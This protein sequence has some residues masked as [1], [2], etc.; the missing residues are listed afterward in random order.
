MHYRASKPRSPVPRLARR[1][2]WQTLARARAP[3]RVP[4]LA[5]PR[6]SQVIFEIVQPL[7]NYPAPRAP[8]RSVR[9]RAPR[10][11]DHARAFER[12]L[13]RRRLPSLPLRSRDPPRVQGVSN[14]LQRRRADALRLADDRR[15]LGREGVGPCFLRGQH[16]RARSLRLGLPSRTPRALAAA[17]AARVRSEI[18]RP[19][20]FGDAREDVE[21]ERRNIR[22]KLRDEERNALR[23]EAADEMNVARKPIELSDDDR[24][25]LAMPAT[26]SNPRPR[27]S[28]GWPRAEPRS[29]APLLPCPAV[30]TRM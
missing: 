14:R 6:R 12:V 10:D 8:G 25:S 29:Q 18:S 13:H 24:R 19:L 4:S 9:A 3:S 21:Q 2:L 22:P 1:R 30:L 7:N 20:L 16:R 15:D 26:S 11:V 23:H 17:R 28:A 5:R 27:Q